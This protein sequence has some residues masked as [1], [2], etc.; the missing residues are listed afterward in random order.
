MAAPFSHLSMVLA[1]YLVVGLLWL[2]TAS[3]RKTHFRL[4]TRALKALLLIC[5]ISALVTIG[6]NAPATLVDWLVAF[7]FAFLTVDLLTF[8]RSQ[9]QRER[10]QEEARLAEVEDMLS[11]MRESNR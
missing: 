1:A 7:G 10:Q 6:L 3:L 2:A 4:F 8:Y 5:A 9:A 11:K